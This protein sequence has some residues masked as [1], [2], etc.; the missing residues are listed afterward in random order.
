M[1][2]A[3]YT[4]DIVKPD[5]THLTK[6]VVLSDEQAVYMTNFIGHIHTNTI[7]CTSATITKLA[8]TSASVA[9]GY[10]SFK[11][12]IEDNI[13]LGSKHGLVPFLP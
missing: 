6:N 4:I 8:P 2:S 10:Q 9:I 11:Q 5:T 13:P 12:Q 3:V 7:G 1:S